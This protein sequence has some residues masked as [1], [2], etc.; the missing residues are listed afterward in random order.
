M[1]PDLFALGNLRESRQVVDAADIDR[2]GSPHNEK[3][4]ESRC[5][6]IGNRLL[7]RDE[8]DLKIC[9][10]RNSPQGVASQACDLTRLRYATMCSGGSVRNQAGVVRSQAALADCFAEST[11]ASHEH[12]NQV[13]QRSASDKKSTS[14]GRKTKEFTNP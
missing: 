10:H 13:C 7:E 9:V 4:Q 12:A 11:R 3:R 14:L 1:K 2:A 5:A 6:V 8:I